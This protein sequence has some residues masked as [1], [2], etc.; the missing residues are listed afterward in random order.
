MSDLPDGVVEDEERGL[1]MDQMRADILLKTEQAK[2]EF[3][4]FV[5]TLMVGIAAIMGAFGALI[6]SLITIGVLKH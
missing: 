1:R 3:P 5:V 4:K 2:L 6:G